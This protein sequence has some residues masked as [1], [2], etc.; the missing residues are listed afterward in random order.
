MWDD[1]E[2]LWLL[3]THKYGNGLSAKSRDRIYRHTYGYRWMGD[4]L[5]KLLQQGAMVVVLRLAKR[6][7]I[8][9]D[10]HRGMDHFEVQ[11]VVDRSWKKYWWRGMG[12]T[13]MSVVKAYPPC[14]RV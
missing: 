13:V 1:V 12:D 8:V 6:V 14:A 7:L 11:C 4:N 5:F 9:L 2:V 10:T 3:Q